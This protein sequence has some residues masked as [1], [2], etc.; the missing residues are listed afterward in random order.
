MITLAAVPR[1]RVPSC[2]VATVS[3]HGAHGTRDGGRTRTAGSGEAVRTVEKV[4]KWNADFEPP[5]G[6]AS[7][8]GLPEKSLSPCVEGFAKP[9]RRRHC[10][11][12]RDEDTSLDRQPQA[13]LWLI[14]RI[15]SA[16]PAHSSAV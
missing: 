7:F 10:S 13:E 12:G 9:S 5:F 4:A 11:R 8:G 2:R 16:T 14:D 1:R 15:I 3:T 6:R